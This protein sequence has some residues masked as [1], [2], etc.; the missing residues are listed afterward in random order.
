M[1][2]KFNRIIPA[3]VIDNFFDDPDAVRQF[4]L[5][6]EFDSPRG[7]Y[8]GY[9]SE[10]IADINP[11]LYNSLNSRVLSLFFDQ[12]KDALDIVVESQFQYI[13]E[14]FEGGWVH[15]DVD[16]NQRNLA[17]VIYLSPNAPLDAGT[18][19]YRQVTEPDYEDLRLR[20]EFYHLGEISDIEKYRQARNRF[21][22]NY[23]KTLEIKNVYNRCIVYDCLEFH[24]ESAFFGNTKDD[25]R[26][27]IVFFMTIV[28]V[29]K[30][31][32]PGYRM[33]KSEII[34]G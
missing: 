32:F 33:K 18:S 23:E 5:S 7:S 14:R 15:Q 2:N 25:A 13:P 17:G 3:S 26:L 10:Q 4:A 30:T 27:T 20:N 19:I 31:S 24:K 16:V 9:R 11:R 6:Q 1:M 12:Y 8:P 21:N 22:S 34:L 29:G 28:P